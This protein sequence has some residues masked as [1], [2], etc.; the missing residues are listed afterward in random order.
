MGT[1]EFYGI[2][3]LFNVVYA[4]LCPKR[5]CYNI[6]LLDYTDCSEILNYRSS[7]V[8]NKIQVQLVIVEVTLEY[9]I[10]HIQFCGIL[11]FGL[12]PETQLLENEV[13]I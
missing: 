5:Q 4:S 3:S 10:S 13:F 1:I 7:S 6:T 12:S 8:I 2:T 9:H 11:A